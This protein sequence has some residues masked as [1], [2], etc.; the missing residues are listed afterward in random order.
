MVAGLY[1]ALLALPVIAAL[2][3]LPDRR[4][5]T[6]PHCASCGYRLVGAPGPLCPECG[7]KIEHN[8]LIGRPLLSPT[9]QKVIES[10]VRI[11]IA[12]AVAGMLLFIVIV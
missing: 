11:M 1:V 12:V 10:S 8:V 4:V 9:R 6:D 2:W 7:C 3:R 5:G